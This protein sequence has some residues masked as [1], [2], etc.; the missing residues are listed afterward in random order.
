VYHTVDYRLSHAQELFDVRA[1]LRR[2]LFARYA[3]CG[4]NGLPRLLKE[5][6]ESEKQDDNHRRCHGEQ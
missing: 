6:S 3:R 2:F 1:H 4:C 5:S